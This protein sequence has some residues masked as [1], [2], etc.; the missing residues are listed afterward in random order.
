MLIFKG[1][2]L[3]QEKKIQEKKKSLTWEQRRRED[4]VPHPALAVDLCVEAA[5]DVARHAAGQRVQDDSCRVD[6][7]V[8]VYVEHAKQRHDDNG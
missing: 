4:D 7:T 5:R 2:W 1:A 6:G 8:A 3:I